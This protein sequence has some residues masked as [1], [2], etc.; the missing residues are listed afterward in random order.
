MRAVG[1]KAFDG[2]DFFAGHFGNGSAARAGGF[3]VDVHGAGSAQRHAAAKFGAGHVESV[4]EHPEQGHLRADVYGLGFSVKG[5]SDGH[6]ALLGENDI[7]QQNPPEMK[8]AEI[9]LDV[10]ALP[11]VAQPGTPPSGKTRE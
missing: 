8:I 6:G 4:A 7:V 2:G 3:A 1:R 10:V 11:S 9:S 5:E